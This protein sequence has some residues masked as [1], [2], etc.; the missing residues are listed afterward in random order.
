[1]FFNGFGFDGWHKVTKLNKFSRRVL[2][3]AVADRLLTETREV[4][5]DIKHN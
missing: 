3:K 5:E 4:V 2:L 1:M